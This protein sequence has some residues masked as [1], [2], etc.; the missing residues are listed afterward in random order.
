M[1][2]KSFNLDRFRRQTETELLPSWLRFRSGTFQAFA[3]VQQKSA[4]PSILT[5]EYPELL[6]HNFFG[7]EPLRLTDAERPTSWAGAATH[8][9]RLKSAWRRYVTDP[10]GAATEMQTKSERLARLWHRPESRVAAAV[11]LEPVAL[12]PLS[13]NVD[14]QGADRLTVIALW[15]R[16]HVVSVDAESFAQAVDLRVR[17]QA[18]MD[19]GDTPAS[20]ELFVAAAFEEVR[21]GELFRTSADRFETQ[22]MKL[23]YQVANLSHGCSKGRFRSKELDRGNDNGMEL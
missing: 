19:S 14:A 13:A 18:A 15:N 4:R 22:L 9:E 20:I 23:D 21:C 3:R 12:P 8:G 5:A 11:R 17:R 16:I 1:P 6:G 10:Q 7:L 2:A